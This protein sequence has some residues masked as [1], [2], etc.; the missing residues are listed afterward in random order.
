VVVARPTALSSLTGKGYIDRMV[1]TRPVLTVGEWL[2]SVPADRRDAIDAVRAAVNERLPRGYEETVD[3]GMLAWGVPL[4]TLPDTH[5]GRP[6]LFA[7]LGAHTKLMT[8]YLMSVYE[9]PEIR[10]E[11]EAAYRK[12]GKKLDMGGSCVHFRTLDDL[13]L[14]VVGDTIARVGVDEFVERYERSR[15][16]RS[17]KRKH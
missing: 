8:I 7:A 10:R 5:N 12:S 1:K 13:P 11:F 3:W 2:A 16:T 14:D 17:P 6:L 9:D 4:A 15:P